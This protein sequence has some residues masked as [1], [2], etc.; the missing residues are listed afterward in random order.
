MLVFAAGCKRDH[1]AKVAESM[2]SRM[3]PLARIDPATAG[4]ISGKVHF[5]GKAPERVEIDMSQDPACG[6]GADN[7]SEQYVEHDGG[8]A[9][10]FVYVKS[11]LNGTRY[12]VPSAPVVLDQKGCQYVPHVVGVMAGQAVEFRN[13]D[14]T[15]H[16]VHTMDSEVSGSGP[17]KSIDISEG[18]MGSPQT[19]VFRHPQLMME[20]RCNNHPWMNAFINVVESPFYAVSDADGHFEIKGLPAGTYT[21]SA[22]HEKLGEQS[23]TV[24]VA[25]QKTSP[26]SFTFAMK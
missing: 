8:L 17:N 12:A 15:M 1:A 25:A 10:V 18:P 11:G 14:P 5:T 20:V 6:T 13:S 3:S 19:E 23:S 22:V 2:D 9:N 16:N 26:A 7:Y 21:I 24:V 4:V